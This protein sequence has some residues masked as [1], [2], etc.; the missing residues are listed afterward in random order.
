M[1]ARFGT[2]T[3]K[4]KSP[5]VNPFKVIA[6]ASGVKVDFV[7]RIVKQQFKEF[8]KSLSVTALIWVA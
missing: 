3:P 7:E 2:L 1:I 5:V 6:D 8:W 4:K